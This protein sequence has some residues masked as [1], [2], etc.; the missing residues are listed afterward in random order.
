M[1]FE[2]PLIGIVD[3]GLKAHPLIDG[4]VVER[5]GVPQNLGTADEWGHGTKVAV[6]MA[7]MA[8]ADFRPPVRC[9][10]RLDWQA[11]RCCS[12]FE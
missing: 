3:S 8:S 2:A 10:R 1:T 11:Y 5:L 6:A 9:G 12:W 4:L 7:D